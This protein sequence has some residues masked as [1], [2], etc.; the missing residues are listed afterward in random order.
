MN[1]VPTVAGISRRLKAVHLPQDSLLHQKTCSFVCNEPPVS[2]WE[3]ITLFLS[4]E[5]QVNSSSHIHYR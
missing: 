5:T 4:H 3:S 1:W 2:R